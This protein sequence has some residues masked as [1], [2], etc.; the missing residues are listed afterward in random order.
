MIELF[1]VL[2]AVGA[3]GPEMIGAMVLGPGDRW[4]T[5]VILLLVL[6]LVWFSVGADG[7]EHR[8]DGREGHCGKNGWTFR[9]R[10]GEGVSRGRAKRPLPARSP[11]AA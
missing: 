3:L 7:T 1:V 8:L 2:G 9:P 4:P 11:L 5:D 6:W 10:E